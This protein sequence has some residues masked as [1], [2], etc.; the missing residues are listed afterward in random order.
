MNT[1]TPPVKTA[2]CQAVETELQTALCFELPADG[3]NTIEDTDTRLTYLHGK[4]V[5][6]AGTVYPRTLGTRVRSHTQTAVQTDYSGNSTAF[7]VEF[8]C[9]SD[10]F[11]IGY[12][13]V[14]LERYVQVEVDGTA[15]DEAGHLLNDSIQQSKTSSHSHN[16]TRFSHDSN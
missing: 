6:P 15:L 9:Y 14:P 16:G 3:S 2:L 11:E 12:L 5:Q 4:V 13:G 1:H 10:S 8:E 7:G